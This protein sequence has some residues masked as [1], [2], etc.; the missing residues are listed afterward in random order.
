MPNFGLGTFFQGEEEGKF[1][2]LFMSQHKFEKV[3][4]IEEI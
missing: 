2:F 3:F 4:L 1:F